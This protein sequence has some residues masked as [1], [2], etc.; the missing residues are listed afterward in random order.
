[1]DTSGVEE[2]FL[3]FTKQG[4]EFLISCYTKEAGLRNLTREV[5][6]L[7]RKVAKKIVMGEDKATVVTPDIIKSLL[8]KPK[9]F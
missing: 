6:S 3:S 5:G 7:C 2:K 4:L 1:M 9:I 8:G